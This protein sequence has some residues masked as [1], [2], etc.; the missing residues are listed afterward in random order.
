MKRERELTELPRGLR[1]RMLPT[2]KL[3]AKAGWKHVLRMARRKGLPPDPVTAVVAAADLVEDLGSFKGLFMK[4]GQLA[5]FLPAREPD[6]ALELLSQLQARG[7]AFAYGEIAK[8]VEAELGDAPERLFDGFERRPIASASIGQVHRARLGGRD[9]AVKVQYPGIER[10]IRE[11]F[12]V[13]GPLLRLGT[14]GIALDGKGL[15]AEL[16][17][18]IAEECDYRR[19]ADNQRLFARLLSSVPFARVPAVIAERSAR[20]VLTMELAEGLDYRRFRATASQAARNRAG[21]AIMRS[22]LESCF[23]RCV[24]NGDPQPGNYVFGEDGSTTFLDFGCVERVDPA[25]IDL[26]RRL[27]VAVLDEDSARARALFEALGFIPNPRRFDWDHQWRALR[28]VHG[29]FASRAPFRFTRRFMEEMYTSQFYGNPNAMRIAM[30]ADA[31]M[32][33]RA[34]YGRFALLTDLG[35]EARWGELMRAMLETPIAPAPEPRAGRS[36]A[37]ADR[38]AARKEATA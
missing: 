23:I 32:L 19:E 38:G 2:A 7:S 8:V 36:P 34:V 25:K 22:G 11:D 4:A 9:V 6:A 5:S 12:A 16:R 37:K 14:F 35:A 10:A 18:R 17:R 13:L 30:P 26:W 27:L 15:L 1:R 3:A 29:G 24:C 33:N 20:R 28:H 31:L 21:E